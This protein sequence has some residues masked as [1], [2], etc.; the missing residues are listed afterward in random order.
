[1]VEKQPSRHKSTVLADVLRFATTVVVVVLLISSVQYWLRPALDES[2]SYLR[3]TISQALSNRRRLSA[4]VDWF[5]GESLVTVN[6]MVPAVLCPAGTF[7]P[8]GSTKL[9]MVT[10]QRDD[11]CLPCPRG[12][13]GSTTGL[14][15]PACTGP[16]PLGKYGSQ[17]GLASAASCQL[18]PPG[19]FGAGTGL[20]GASCTGTK[21]CTAC[22]A[23]KYS[24]V[25]GAT[26]IQSCLTCPPE[27]R[28]WGCVWAVQPRDGQDQD[29]QEGELRNGKYVVGGQ[30]VNGLGLTKDPIP[31][32]VGA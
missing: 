25:E 20:T 21:C 5:S 11:G 4:K 8:P 9:Q 22:A 30:V 31:V 6:G 23:G 2:S 15:S 24:I 13:F 14:V 10:G 16:C 29:H 3:S 27:F 1:M 12:R 26:S 32:K 28:A 17:I 19:R 7:R 18:C